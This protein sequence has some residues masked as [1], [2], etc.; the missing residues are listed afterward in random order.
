MRSVRNSVAP[1]HQDVRQRLWA[2]AAKEMWPQWAVVRR[3][4]THLRACVLAHG[5]QGYEPFRLETLPLGRE[6]KLWVME[7]ETQGDG[8]SGLRN[9]NEIGAFQKAGF[10]Y[11]LHEDVICW[12][13]WEQFTSKLTRNQDSVINLQSKKSKLPKQ[14][15]SFCQ[16]WA[17]ESPQ[18]SEDENQVVKLQGESS[19]NIRRQ[20]FPIKTTGEFW[21]NIYLR[22]TH[23]HQSRYQQVDVKNK[24]CKCDHC[25]MTRISHHRDGREIHKSKQAYSH[26]DCGK[27]FM[28]KSCQHSITHSGERHHICSKCGE[29]IGDSSVFCICQNIHAGE[30]CG[31]NDK[32]G[33][34]FSQSS[35]LQNHQGVNTGEKPYRCQVCA[36][37]FNQNSCLPTHETLHPGGDLYKCDT[38][39][40]DSSH[41]LDLN[42]CCVD[43]TGEKSSE[44]EI[45]D[46]G[47]NQT[48]H[49]QAHQRAHPRDKTSK[50]EACD[51]LVNQNPGP[52]QRVHTGE[53]P[54]KCKVCGKDFSKASNLQAHQR[55][56]T[57]EKPYKCDVCDKNFSRNSHLQAHQR[58]H[59]GEKPYKCETCGKYFTQI[60]HLQVHQRVH[61]G[62]KPYKCE[63]CGKG[64][65]QSSHLQDHQRVH[66]GEKP[67]KCDVCGKGFSWSSHLQAHQR[68]HTGEKPY[69]CEECGKGFI[70][71]SYLHVHQRI[72]TG[73]KPYKCGMCGK[74]FN[75]TSHLQ[76]HWRVHTGDKPY[77]CFD[78]GKGFSK[79]SRL[80]VHQRVH[81]G[82]KSSTRDECGK[83]VL[84]NADLPFSS[85]NPHSREYL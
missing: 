71:N 66:T 10:R 83:S 73:E 49:L 13:I 19:H 76:A 4:S 52:P 18:V 68:V 72:H 41:S 32:C 17:G 79:S 22:E 3:R 62:E 9:Q 40:K 81:S 39:G 65:C 74:S 55:I 11:L 63:T 84:Q 15:D 78:C 50:W 82:D 12:Q 59:T 77:K 35:H 46:K 34:G 54:Y 2:E 20:E 6:E 23:N 61:T 36:K 45:R 30:K 25:V 37:S 16:M 64:F 31:R 33:G 56:H 60:S 7:T 85:E 80:Q 24:Q 75:Q 44:C 21:K 48:S 57:G 67:Y 58:V 51:R 5:V 42:I 38:C 29:D 53:K 47:F 1:C 69:K 14:G 28:R 26:D 8:P 43:D 70:W 27:D